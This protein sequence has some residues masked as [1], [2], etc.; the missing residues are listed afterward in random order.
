M[1]NKDAPSAYEIGGIVFLDKN[2]NKYITLCLSPMD[3]FWY[4]YE[5]EMV[6]KYD[7]DYFIENEYNNKN[8]YKPCILLYKTLKIKN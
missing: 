4:L 5:D 6:K 8:I 1:E 7:Y 2:K 3:Q